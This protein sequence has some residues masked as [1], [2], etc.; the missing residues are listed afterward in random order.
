M[1]RTIEI[2]DYLGNRHDADMAEIYTLVQCATTPDAEVRLI[3]DPLYELSEEG[4]VVVV[5]IDNTPSIE[6]ATDEEVL[7]AIKEAKS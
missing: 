5:F 3:A 1:K 6:S 7:E 2:Q 4:H